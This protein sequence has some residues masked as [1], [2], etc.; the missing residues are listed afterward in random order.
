MKTSSRLSFKSIGERLAEA[1]LRAPRRICIVT[2]L[3]V[4]LF[5]SGIRLARFSTD[6]RI[7]FSKEDPGLT[8]FDR[9]EKTF[10]KTD[11]VLFVIHPKDGDVFN[12]KTLAAVQDLTLRSWTLPF[13]SRVD[14]LSNFQIMKALADEMVVRDLVSGDASALSPQALAELKQ[15]AVAE[16]ILVGSLLSR[17]LHTAAVNVS[18]HLPGAAPSEVTETAAQAQRIAEEARARYPHL[19]IRV[20]GMAT[21]NDAFMQASVRDLAI[22]MPIMSL[23]MLIGMLLVMRSVSAT[24]AVGG[25]IGVS[26]AMTMAFAGFAKYPLSPPCVAAPMITLTVAVADGVHIVLAVRKAMQDGLSKLHAIRDSIRGN[27]EAITYTWLTTV[28]GFVCLNYSEAPPVRHLANMTCVGVTAAYVFSFTLLP[29]LLALLPLRAE[30]RAA[31]APSQSPF[32]ARLSD[33]VIRRRGIVLASTLLL[34]VGFGALALRL[35]TNDQFVRY[36]APSITFRK[37]ADFTIK[38]LSGIYRLEFQVGSGQSQGVTDP[39]YLRTLDGFASYLRAQP[40]VDH[41]YSVVDL[42]KRL[43]QVLHDGAPG[44]YQ[45]P[46]TRE[47]ASQNLLVYEMGLPEGLG[48]TDRVDLDKQSS[49]VTVTVKDISTKELTAFARRA[50]TWLERSAPRAMWAQASGPVVIFSAL[51]ERNA[52]SMLSG[53]VLSLVLISLCMIMVLRSL[54][55]GLLSVIPNVIPIV[56][57][58]GLWQLCVGQMNIVATVAGS[59]SLGIIVDDTIHFLTKYKD[60]TLE[61]GLTP[62]AAMRKTLS[63]IG[64][65]MIGTSVIL[66]MGFLVLTFSSFQ[67]TSYLGW[68]SAIIVSIAPL[69]DLVLAP[70]LVVVFA[71][72]SWPRNL[73]RPM[74]PLWDRIIHKGVV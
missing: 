71:D 69:A 64:P 20:S 16:P 43:H 31:R 28:V 30:T 54:K 4:A 37:D 70:A 74:R 25:I 68:L 59:I 6:Y 41:V 9:L 33:F 46:S 72:L 15:D 34:T 53:D 42:E 14:S 1:I 73:G 62:E 60:A 23:V 10:S 21:M 55:L 26:A 36:F 39:D 32:F 2:L 40:E 57:G 51:S 58:Y 63:H 48:L 52:R 3:V 19:E 49:R 66:V 65:A 11:N 12:R 24:L 29:A 56:F 13:A 18:L 50:E 47:E 7:F 67:M 27:L 17:D 45:V 35:E 8:A 22:M 44:A 38:H 5:S 61:Q